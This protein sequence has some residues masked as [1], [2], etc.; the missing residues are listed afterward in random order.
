MAAGPYYF[1]S[2]YDYV[3]EADPN[4]NYGYPYYAQSRVQYYTYSDGE[5]VTQ[6]RTYWNILR[7]DVQS[8]CQID[9]WQSEAPRWDIYQNTY[10]YWNTPVYLYG[11]DYGWVPKYLD[12]TE[13]YYGWTHFANPSTCGGL[14]FLWGVESGGWIMQTRWTGSSW[15]WRACKHSAGDPDCPW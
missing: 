9:W 7:T 10:T 8:N 2:P 6:R 1:N 11:W 5:R 4:H 15:W 12:I 13:M 14:Y 3:Y